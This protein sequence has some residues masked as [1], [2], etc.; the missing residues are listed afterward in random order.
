MTSHDWLQLLKTGQDCLCAHVLTVFPHT[1][2][3]CGEGGLKRGETESVGEWVRVWED[4]R[5]AAWH[6]GGIFK[7]ADKR[8]RGS[9]WQAGCTWPDESAG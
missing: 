1:G 3:V 7:L 2:I 6:V 8:V 9:T 5:G 4:R